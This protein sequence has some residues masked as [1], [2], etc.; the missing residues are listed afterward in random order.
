MWT[1]LIIF[2]FVLRARAKGWDAFTHNLAT[3][4]APLV[5]LFVEQATKQFFSELTTPH[6]N[7]IFAVAP[8]GILTAVVSVMGVLGSAS[9]RAFV[10]RA[11]EGRP[12]RSRTLLLYSYDVCE[13][14]NNG[15]IARVFGRPQM[16]EFIFDEEKTEK[17]EKRKVQEHGKSQETE[18]S[19]GIN[20]VFYEFFSGDKVASRPTAG[21]YKP[22]EYE[23][24]LVRRSP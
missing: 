24:M 16:L 1:L 17:G 22:Q 8:L 10:G 5:A 11:Q 23:K 18:K 13:L 12:S 7:I 14:W 15:G 19:Y 21:I 9:L 6:E 3:G 2:C 20:L 4:L